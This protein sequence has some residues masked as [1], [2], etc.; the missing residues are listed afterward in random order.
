MS[1]NTNVTEKEGNFPSQNAKKPLFTTRDLVKVALL[2]AMS[3]ALQFLK[4]PLPIFPGFY[5]IDFSDVPAVVAAVFI[6]PVGGIFVQ[7]I[8]NIYHMFSS[9]TGFVGEFANF[10]MG[11]ALIIPVGIM[12][13]KQKTVKKVTVGLVLGVILMAIVGAILNAYVLLPLYSQLY[14]GNDVMNIVAM[15]T[16]IFPFID[17]YWEFIL[18]TVIP[19]NIV[20][21][22]LVAIIS[23]VLFEFLSK[24]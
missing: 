5:E 12:C 1:K 9:T 22:G 10:A 2:G 19:F 4:T 20:K 24:R 21:G 8:K 11:S 6:G 17:T 14:F 16:A 18:Y 7:L 3:I 23:V 13:R 15:S